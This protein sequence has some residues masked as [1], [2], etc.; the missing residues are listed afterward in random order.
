M[1]DSKIIPLI[2]LLKLRPQMPGRVICLAH[3]CFDLLHYGHIEHLRQAKALGDYL[4]VTITADQFVIKGPGRPAF[5]QEQRAAHLAALEMVDC[6]AVV[7]DP[8]ALPAIE[9]LRP[10]I[11]CKGPD[12]EGREDGVFAQEK[13]LVQSFG[14][15]MVFTS[16]ETSSSSAIL[17]GTGDHLRPEVAVF[18]AKVR[19]RY[20]ADDV[21]GWLDKT[22]QLK[23]FVIGEPIR[24][25]YVF[26]APEG[27]SAKDS[28]ICFRQL[29]QEHWD[30][31]VD[32]VG[33]HLRALC[34]RVHVSRCSPQPLI[35]RR[36]ILEPFVTKL[37]ETATF[38]QFVI[39]CQPHFGMLAEA[40]LV[41]AADFGL[42]LF[43][44]A[45][46]T[47]AIVGG[48][49]FLA[50]TVQSNSLNFGFNLL[51][52]WPRADYV[53]VDEDELRL[54]RCDKKGELVGL[55]QAERERLGARHLTVTL[56]HRGCLIVDA[57]GFLEAPALAD[58]V[59]D[60]LG[61]GDAF[62]GVTAP[63]ACLGAPKEVLA[64]VGSAAAA[65][66]VSQIGNIP[67]DR[68]ALRKWLKGTLK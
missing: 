39:N 40:D 27:K 16:G 66:E 65:L 46:E 68:A 9:M 42:G 43:P 29:W 28:I 54:A 63:L 12:Y 50:L 13:A 44:T 3:G 2:D 32:V 36:Y 64:L 45:E 59:L 8:T 23:V 41:V 26:V 25:E 33:G 37:F 17:N 7:D 67:T 57:E 51:T 35:K 21:L 56:G 14:G 1:A 47:K 10:D 31:G 24:D 61:A 11:Y 30:G 20:S 22:T 49:K 19:A 55:A 6:V 53:V 52:K 60:R 18:L 58:R 38:S 48:A 62:L 15:R 34:E 4:V 5:T